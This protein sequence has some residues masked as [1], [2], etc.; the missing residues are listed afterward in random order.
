MFGSN[1][2][3]QIQYSSL[4]S[5]INN[6]SFIQINGEIRKRISNDERANGITDI[7]DVAKAIKMAMVADTECVVLCIN[8]PGG[9]SVGIEETG[10][11]L[12]QLTEIKKVWVFCDTICASAVFWLAS[13]SNGIFITPS[14]EVGSIGVFAK[15]IDYSQSLK[16]QGINVQT[17]SAGSMKTMGQGE[18]PLTDEESAYIQN[19]ID[20]QWELFKNVIKSN[21]GDVKEESMQGQLFAGQKAVEANLADMIVQD[22]DEFMSLLTSPE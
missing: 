7:D 4:Y 11:L 17:F 2:L 13:F 12:L 3:N 15:I 8:S 21:R 20:T 1:G 14:A 18:K 6:I 19:D 9:S 22:W 16:Q 10:N 5:E